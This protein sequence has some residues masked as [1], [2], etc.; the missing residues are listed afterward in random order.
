MLVLAGATFG[1]GEYRNGQIHHIKVATVVSPGAG[2]ENILLV[3]S[4]SR[5]ALDNKQTGAFGSC[6]A[7]VTGVNSDVVM[8]LRLDA[9]NHRVSLLSIPRDTFIPNARPGQANRIDSALAYGPT[10]VVQAV[11]QDFGI[12]INHFVEL[13]FDGFQNIV[14]A[15]GGLSMYF[16]NELKDA[17]SGLSV[18]ETGCVHLGAFQALAVVRARHLYYLKDGQWLYDG[19]G[20][21]GRIVRVHEFLRVLAGAVS[22]KGL[23]NPFTDNALVGALAP[24]LTVDDGFGLQQM[25]NLVLGFH[26]TN[27]AAVPESTLPVIVDSSFTYLYKGYNYGAIVFPSEPGARRA[28]TA[29]MGAP[30]PGASL[31]PQQVSVAVTGGIGQPSATTTTVSQLQALGYRVVSGGESTPV[32]PV[33]ETEVL[34]S[35]GYLAAGERV[36]ESL[37]GAVA[38]GAEPTKTAA[39]VTVVTGSNFSVVAP[40]A[41]RQASGTTTASSQILTSTTLVSAS[42]TASTSVISGPLEA[43]TPAKV[44]LPSY[45]PRSCPST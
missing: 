5:C 18:L 43:P 15:L 2:P 30:L 19:S 42:T 37:H 35:P 6:A 27:A 12:P 24:Q 34:Y 33:S 40:S 39:E 13:N 21:L 20:D 38:L 10:Q 8:V 4:T 26:G 11:E 17:D 36:I 7:G 23:G 28:I 25:I 9:Q 44:A 22:K 31:K 41:P 3:G 32:G 16:P 29:F 14:K 45:D 1:Y